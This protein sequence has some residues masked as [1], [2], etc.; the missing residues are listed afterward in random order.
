MNNR[1]TILILSFFLLAFSWLGLKPVQAP[2]VLGAVQQ[3]GGQTP[4]NSADVIKSQTNL[5]LVDTIVADKK[6]NYVRDLE[7]K[8]FKVFEDNKE[9]KIISFSKGTEANAPGAAAGRHYMVL[10]FDNSTMNLSDQAYARQAAGKFIETNVADDHLMAVVDFGGTLHI[11]QNFTA[12]ADKLKRVVSN[13]KFSAVD[14]NDQDTTQVASAGDVTIPSSMA[15]FGARSMLLAIRGLAKNLQPIPGRKTVILFS[16]GFPL[17]IESRAEL[18]ATVDACNKANVA[19]YSLDVRGLLAPGGSIPAAANPNIATPLNSNCPQSL[20]SPIGQGLK[21]PRS[22]GELAFLL[23][24]P[25]PWPQRPTGGGGSA[26][27][28]GGG[29]GGGGGAGAGGGGARGGGTGGGAGGA[30]G[31]GGGGTRGGPGTGSGGTGGTGTGRGAGGGT[32]GTGAGTRAGGGTT[33]TFGPANRF[34]NNPLNQP[35]MLLPQ[36]P[37]S[38]TV[39]QDVLYA[40]A[41]GTGGFPIFN[42]NDLA[43]GLEKIAREMNEYYVLGYTPSAKMVE[44]ACHAIRVQ[45]DRGD[46]KARYRSGYCDVPSADPLAGKEEG[47]TLE[48]MAANPSAGSIPVTLEAPYFF[49]GPNTARV[50]MCLQVPAESLAFEKD[51]GRFHSDVNVLGIAYREDGSVGARFSDVDK[52]DLDK[53]GK[54]EFSKTDFKYQNSFEIAPGKYNLKVVLSSGGQTYG[55]YEMPL[56]IDPYNGKQ[57][58]ISGLVLSDTLQPVAQVTADLEA[59]M[60]EGKTPLVFHGVQ[61]VPSSS[62]RF[63]QKEKVALYVE[64]YEPVPIV[65]GMPRV[66]FIYKLIDRKTGQP[67]FTSPTLLVNQDA[68]TPGP[69]IAVGSFL[70]MGQIKPGEYRLEVQARD[71]NQNASA[72][73]TTDLKVE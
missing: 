43:G 22:D 27:G 34:G 52:L 32:T 49:T 4:I 57:F 29:G 2:A 69:V 17:T 62:N 38:V 41:Q 7:G 20:Q 55:K 46:T 60:L 14:P 15:N 8:D 72:V 30:G 33:N 11:A 66:G 51:K 65:N 58:A 6:G 19:V 68:T 61:I 16:A 56:A 12:S 28:G 35:C 26:A 39:N 47:K 45:V 24:P 23:F 59:A 37:T 73:R 21:Y 44:G 1:R 53:E 25:E 42:T 13:V 36:F 50:D 63:D 64:I 48:Q 18:Q 71:S 9:Q 5:V 40:L 10:F 70:D 67:A 3:T 31:T 54:K